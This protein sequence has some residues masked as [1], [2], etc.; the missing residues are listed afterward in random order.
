M[1]IDSR[2]CKKKTDTPIESQKEKQPAN[3]E[4]SAQLD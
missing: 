3:T 4:V 1:W 2:T